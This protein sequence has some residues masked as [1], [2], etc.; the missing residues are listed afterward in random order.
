ME[1]NKKE[2]SM[3]ELEQGNGGWELFDRIILK[4]TH[5]I[6]GC[7]VK[8]RETPINPPPKIR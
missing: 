2:L 1:T 3:E 6:V 5:S 8:K 4:I 7:G